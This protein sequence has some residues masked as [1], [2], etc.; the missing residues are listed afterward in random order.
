M[1][2]KGRRCAASRDTSIIWSQAGDVQGRGS[3]WAAM[4]Q[5]DAFGLV[6]AAQLA[7]LARKPAIW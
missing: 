5:S 2:V 4:G 6:R 3:E 7:Q 1:A